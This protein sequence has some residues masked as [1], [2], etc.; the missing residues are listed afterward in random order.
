MNFIIV[1]TAKGLKFYKILNF[2]APITHR[3]LKL[4]FPRFLSINAITC[5]NIYSFSTVSIYVDYKIYT[6]NHSLTIKQFM[7]KNVQIFLLISINHNFPSV[8]HF[9][10]IC[11]IDICNT[12]TCAIKKMQY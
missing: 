10:A 6:T 11:A 4:R 9:T 8:I 7:L 3:K 2:S 1:R 12:K 5:K